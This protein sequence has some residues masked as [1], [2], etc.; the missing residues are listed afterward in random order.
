MVRHSSASPGWPRP[1]SLRF[2]GP[3]PACRLLLV[4][5]MTVPRQVLP[6]TVYLVTRRCLQRAFLLRPSRLTNA[7]V[8]YLLAVA[9]ERYGIRLNAFCVLSNPILL[10]LTPPM[11]KLPDF[12]Q[13][14]DSLIARA[15][16]ASI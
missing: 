11:A 13:Y 5:A 6:G 3:H 2:P 7:T 1:K 12:Y 8:G 14:M 10:E 15:I 4:C 9:A 16:N